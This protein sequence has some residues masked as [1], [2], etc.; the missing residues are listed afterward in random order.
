VTD[1]EK[2]AAREAQINDF[3]KT[4]NV[5]QEGPK[6]MAQAPQNH[7]QTPNKPATPPPAAPAAAKA[8]TPADAPKGEDKPAKTKRAKLRWV[9]TK[10]GSF[11]VRSFKD[12]TDKHGAPKDPWGNEMV[13]KAGQAFGKKLTDEEKAARAEAKAAEAKRKEAMTDEERLAE[14]KAKREMKQK[15]KQEAV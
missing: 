11:W 12:V 14:A 9:S 5:K 6:T 1:K 15:A 13:V 3:A 8:A 2:R 4:H 10:D 7:K